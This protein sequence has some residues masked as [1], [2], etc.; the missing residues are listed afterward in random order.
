MMKMT[1]L[2]IAMLFFIG[3]SGGIGLLGSWFEKDRVVMFAVLMMLQ[4]IAVVVN[5]GVQLLR[6]IRDNTNG[7]R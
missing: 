6:Q 7:E 1:P 3:L 4:F 2:G 5:E